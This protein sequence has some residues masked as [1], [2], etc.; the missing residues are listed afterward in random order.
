[1]DPIL[2]ALLATL[3]TI[4]FYIIFQ[5]WKTNQYWKERGIPHSKPTLFVGNCM[6]MIL[7]RMP[8]GQLHQILCEKFET[9][10]LFGYYEFMKPTL[11]VKDIDYIEKILIKHFAHFT[12]HGLPSDDERNPLDSNLVTMTGRRWKAVRNRLS[13]IFTTG[14]LKLMFETMSGFGEQLVKHI[15][16]G[17]H[18]DVEL[19]ETLN[20]FAMDTIG[21]CIFGIDS[22]SLSNPDS[23][24]RHKGQQV[25]KLDLLTT[26]KLIILMNFPSLVKF[27]NVTF[28]KPHVVKYFSEIIKDTMNYRRDNK[29]ERNDFIQLMMQL[30][31]KG[32]VEVHTKDLAD[33]YLGIDIT[34]YSK[35]KFELTNDQITGHAVSFLTAGFDTTS[36]TLIFTLYEL[37]RNPW[38]QEKVREEI[39]RELE[40]F[41]SLT[42][43]ALKEMHYLEQCIKE[44]LRIYSPAQM[45]IRSCTKQYTFINAEVT[46]APGQALL[47]PSTVIHNDP[48]YYPEPKLYRPERF[49]PGHKIPVCAYLPFGNGPRICIAMRFAILK[50]KFCIA[51]LLR[52]YSISLSPKTKQPITI[53]AR[54]L[55]TAPN[56]KLYF[57]IR[58]LNNS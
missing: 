5:A 51:I 23:E 26:I 19:M 55:L 53:S 48:S 8:P 41:G 13:P 42:Y 40:Q 52:N 27:L 36:L 15:D 28:T 4:L 31:D 44:A 12:D 29:L 3:F 17:Q 35:E 20:C 21:S 38:I 11:I 39:L 32:Y 50:M 54:H 47:I 10:P 14:K 46:I 49:D 33:D 9:E 34:A 58:K 7:G 56:E 16:N 6:P 24:F 18:Q 43:D 1:M 45:L 2:V 25:L 57:N 30:Q 37:S 22:G